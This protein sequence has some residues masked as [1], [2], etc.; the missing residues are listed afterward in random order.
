MAER[1]SWFALSEAREDVLLVGKRLLDFYNGGEPPTEDEEDFMEAL[2]RMNQRIEDAPIE[3]NR[4]AVNAALQKVVKP[5]KARK[6]RP[7]TSE[8]K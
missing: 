3:F 2:E 6:E 8:S 1:F 5:I 4:R 7:C